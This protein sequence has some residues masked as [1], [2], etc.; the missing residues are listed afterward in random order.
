[1][2]F[3]SRFA[4]SAEYRL[5]DV[6]FSK[7]LASLDE[8]CRTLEAPAVY[9]C[10]GAASWLVNFGKV[11]ATVNDELQRRARDRDRHPLRPVKMPAVQM[12]SS[13]IRS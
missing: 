6:I 1:M 7:E 2:E 13:T 11:M 3:L 5:L 12:A 8:K 9:R 10:Q 4:A